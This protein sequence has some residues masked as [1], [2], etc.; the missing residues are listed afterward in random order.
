LF[1]VAWNKAGLPLGRPLSRRGNLIL[2]GGT[3][4][5]SAALEEPDTAGLRVKNKT[6]PHSEARKRCRAATGTPIPQTEFDPEA[7]S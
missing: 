5:T 2:P 7:E 4:Q 6:Q 3:I 1:N